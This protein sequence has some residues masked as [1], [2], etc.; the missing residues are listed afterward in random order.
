MKRI[1][2]IRGWKDLSAGDR[3]A[4]VAMGSFD[5]LHLGHQQVIGLAAAA[6][7]TLG[8][9]LGV[10]T[11]D[12]HPRVY[13]RPDE[14]A[15]RLMKPDQQARALEKLGVDMLYVLPLEAELAG[16]TDREFAARVLHQGLG[17]RHVAVGF[18]NSFGKD[19]TGSPETMRAYGREMGFG[20]SVAAPVGAGASDA[21]EGDKYSSTAVREAM[22]DGRPEAAAEILGRPFAI[23]G[24]VQRGRQLGRK[25]GFPTAN[26]DLADYV[27]PRFG[28]YAVRTRL[29]DGREFAGV[30]NIGVNPTVQGVTRPL[31]EV[32]LFDFDED[33]Y[34]RIIETD[35]IAFL[36]PEEKFESLEVMTEQVMADARRARDVLGV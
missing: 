11:F 26:V 35:L 19:R 29:S 16:M 32:W 12:P 2:V 25:L 28:V 1:R 3:G 8:A 13:F 15:F 7:Q 6:A 14:P 22:R 27:T 10:I 17:A 33:I 9:P 36:R 18:D 21:G 24:P 30:A 31:L 5:G 23:E 4:S 34:D 20:V